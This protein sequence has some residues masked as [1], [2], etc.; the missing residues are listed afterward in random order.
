MPL[1]NPLTTV[2]PAEDQ[3][4]ATLNAMRAMS[5]VQLRVPTTA[6]VLDQAWCEGHVPRQNNTGGASV[7]SLNSGG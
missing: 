6:N 2:P 4:P 1:A 5:E 7:H 3:S